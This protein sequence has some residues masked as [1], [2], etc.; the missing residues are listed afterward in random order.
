MTADPSIR[1]RPATPQDRFLIRRWASD[2]ALQTIGETSA[3]VQAQIT[4][5]MDSAAALPRIIEGDG[6]PIGYAYAAEAGQWTEGSPEG[7]PSGA[8]EVSYFLASPKYD[9]ART[10][11][12]VLAILTEE[13]FATTLSL[14]C[15]AVVSIRNE[16]M[17]RAYESAGFHW[18]RVLHDPY[19]GPS[20]LMLKERPELQ[21]AR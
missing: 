4:L 19:W 14:A 13:V 8:W 7:V 3:S 12:A 18:L 2:P 16:A 11:A 1:L 21:P 5:A 9:R 17:A 10:G 15:S 6:A 20:W